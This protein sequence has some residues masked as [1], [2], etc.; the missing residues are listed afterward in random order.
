MIGTTHSRIHE[1][2]CRVR[3]KQMRRERNRC[4]HL[5]CMTAVTAGAMGT[6]LYDVQSPGIANVSAGFGTVLIRSDVSAYVVIGILLFTAGVVLSVI[7]IRHRDRH[8]L[9]DTYEKEEFL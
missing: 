2:Q 5:A 1:I 3:R 7:G 9:N 4:I 6:L 8:H